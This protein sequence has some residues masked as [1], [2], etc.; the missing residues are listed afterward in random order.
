MAG[1][2]PDAPSRRMAWDADGTVAWLAYGQTYGADWQHVRPTFINEL[3]SDQKWKLNSEDATNIKIQLTEHGPGIDNQTYAGMIF[4]EKR[5]LYGVYWYGPTTTGGAFQLYGGF[6]YIESSPDTTNAID[7]TWTQF[8]PDIPYVQNVSD[9]KDYFR[10]WA[11]DIG[12]RV[13]IL[14]PDSPALGQRGFHWIASSPYSLETAVVDLNLWH[15]YGEIPVSSTPDILLFIDE[16]TGLE[17]DRPLD[18]GDVPRGASFEYQ[19]R[20]KNNSATL[21][22]NSTVLSFEALTGPS[23]TWYSIKDYL[24][25]YGSTLTITTVTPG[26]TYPSAGPIT[27][28]LALAA[29]APL[30]VQDARLRMSGTVWT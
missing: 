28:K 21:T 11:P 20:V 14:E 23:D 18:W 19:I 1:S 22:A 10:P 25:V 29:D 9:I 15:M 17:F 30:S 4:P 7:G 16:A 26:A 12:H 2:Y 6:Y 3:T 27:I 5:D 24:G 8:I 13:M